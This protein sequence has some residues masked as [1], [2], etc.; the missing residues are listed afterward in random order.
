ML[1]G[2]YR[3]ELTCDEPGCPCFTAYEGTDGKDCVRAA[4]ADGWMMHRDSTCTCPQ[5]SRRKR[6]PLDQRTA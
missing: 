1:S 2:R 5:C 6:A 3:I 4:R